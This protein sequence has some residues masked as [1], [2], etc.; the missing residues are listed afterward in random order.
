M[1]NSGVQTVHWQQCIGPDWRGE[2]VYCGAV[3]GPR[4]WA[5]QRIVA[6]STPAGWRCCCISH[7]KTLDTYHAAVRAMA[8]GV[9]IANGA[10][11]PGPG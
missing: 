3:L 8:R 6:C 4:D 7:L 5:Q 1:A 11:D 9:A 2:C 10:R